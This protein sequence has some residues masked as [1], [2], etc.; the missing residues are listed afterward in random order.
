MRRN[1]LDAAAAAWDASRETLEQVNWRI[2]DGVQADQLDARA[3]GI[4]AKLFS[5][6]ELSK[7]RIERVLEI[8]S[9]VGYLMEA[10][11]R[12]T[13]KHPDR[14]EIVGLDISASMIAKAK[15]R[16]AG[17]PSYQSGLFRFE[18]YDG[19]A[20]PFP[21]GHFDLIY[22]A[23]ALQHI[24]KPYVYN[25]FFEIKRTLKDTGLAALQF[26]PFSLLPQQE[27]QWPWRTEILQQIGQVPSGHWHH[28]YSSD[29]LEHVLR[30]G[31]GFPHVQIDASDNL[32]VCV[33][34]T[35]P[36][37]HPETDPARV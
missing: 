33:A 22:S 23:A 14:Q 18:S 2:H 36:A 20:M 16:L 37:A 31:T 9:G 4:I 19:V 12:R 29:E 13:R 21:D 15:E 26:L 8:G 25:L 6:F 28:Y 7:L 3:D 32:W 5:L 30:H 35:A 1:D 24:P 17:T 34:K 10:V 11:E 27:T